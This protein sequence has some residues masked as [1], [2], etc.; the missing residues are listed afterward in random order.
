MRLPTRTD[1][2]RLVA[3]TV[4]L[5]L[6]G[7][8]YALVALVAAL[9]ALVVFTVPQNWTL[10]VDLVLGGSLPLASRVGILLDLFPFLGQ[11][12]TAAQGTVLVVA[13]GLS[14]VN[15][16]MAVY[17]VREH[18]V[19]LRSG[20]GGVV[21]LVLGTLGAGCAACGTAVL[22]GLLSLVGGAGLLAALPLEGL[23]VTL[24]AVLVIALSIWWLA[25]GMRGGEI[26]GCPVEPP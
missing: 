15:V 17:H 3:R 24:L 13:A 21:G 22:A 8:G 16:A 23:E 5:V 11:A 25:E 7:P 20:T 9:G 18:R 12:Y 4:R 10:F 1:D 6:G 26:R 19:S 14:G 2:L